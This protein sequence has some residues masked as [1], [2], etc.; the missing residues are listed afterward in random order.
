MTC[1]LITGGYFTDV[2]CS[3]DTCDSL[4]TCAIVRRWRGSTTFS[5]WQT[6]RIQA[7]SEVRCKYV[8]GMQG[9]KEHVVNNIHEVKRHR[10]LIVCMLRTTREYRNKPVTKLCTA[11][12]FR[13][14]LLQTKHNFQPSACYMPGLLA[15]AQESKES[16]HSSVLCLSSSIVDYTIHMMIRL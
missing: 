4:M 2:L 9:L 10:Q 12:A 7:S 8:H 6:T 3:H 16:M 13:L 14:E 1:A 5:R 15:A 11:F